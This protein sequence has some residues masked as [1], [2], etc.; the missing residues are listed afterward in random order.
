MRRWERWPILAMLC[1][2]LIL[3]ACG[4]AALTATPI[5]DAAATPLATT[6]TPSSTRL[7]SAT[8]ASPSAASA[9]GQEAFE[10]PPVTE[11]ITSTINAQVTSIA[12]SWKRLSDLEFADDL[13]GWMIIAEPNSAA[14]L[15]AT[16]DGGKSW[17]VQLRGMGITEVASASITQIWVVQNGA[18]LSSTDGGEHWQVL[19]SDP[20]LDRILRL[21][22]SDPLHGWATRYGSRN[23]QVLYRTADGGQSWEQIAAPNPCGTRRGDQQYSFVS[24][25]VGWMLC[26]FDGAGGSTP[27]IV[28][29]TEDGAQTWTLL[30]ET[31][32]EHQSEYGLE[33]AS[34]SLAFFFLDE[35]VGW[36]SGQRS[37]LKTTD[38]GV[39]WHPVALPAAPPD[40]AFRWVRFVSEQ[41][42]YLVVTGLYPTLLETTDGGEHWTP[43]YNAVVWPS[44]VIR[45]T[46]RNTGIAAGTPVDGGAVLRSSDGGESWQQIGRLG[47]PTVKILQFSFADA[48]NGWAYSYDGGIQRQSPTCRLDRTT[49]SGATWRQLPAPHSPGLLC[50]ESGVSI[51]FIDRQ[52]GFLAHGRMGGSRLLVTHD[53]GESFQSV[54]QFPFSLKQ[55]DFIDG[56]TGWAISGEGV[57]IDVVVM[58][59]DGG[60][61]WR[62][63]PRNFRIPWTPSVYQGVQNGVPINPI[64]ENYGASAPNLF[65]GGTAWLL[66]TVFDPMQR[67]LLYLRTDVGGKSWTRYVLTVKQVGEGKQYGAGTDFGAPQF[68]DPEYG[69]LIG[70]GEIYRTTDGGRTWVQLRAP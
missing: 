36:F 4:E 44:G 38:G 1:L 10:L 51:D 65:P 59:E 62:A 34:G 55:I 47:Q 48:N 45:F 58:T 8:V 26:S 53:G 50:G 70:S 37:A 23:E 40:V 12:Q 67:A 13:H 56:D 21:D 60:R 66:V 25:L 33:M 32:R 54:A 46:G 24:P 27:K 9:P 14:T 28:F 5:A 61:T 29:K 39:T 18:I 16:A 35:H 3:G 68:V 19:D 69:W 20:P 22:F 7:A 31:T 11:G 15:Y 43:I 64:L 17:G 63:L 49:D 41:H 6:P 57:G 30:T 42:G 52:T 2:S